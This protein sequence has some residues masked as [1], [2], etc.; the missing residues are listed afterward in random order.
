MNQKVSK[1][2]IPNTATAMNILSGFLSIIFVSQQDFHTGALLIFMA[3]FFD[4]IDGILARL[5]KTTSMF[6]VELDSIADV[7]SFG[8]APAFLI[9]YS[10]LI[11]YETVGIILSSLV[12]LFGA[13]R[14]ARFNVQIE[15]IQIKLDFNGLPIPVSALVIASLVL[16]YHNG[17]NIIKPFDSIVIPS[18][19]V[20]SL[21]MVSNIKYNTLP[22]VNKLD[23]VGKLL[24]TIISVGALVLLVLTNGEAIFYL[25]WFHILYGIFRYLY[26]KFFNNEN[27]IEIKTNK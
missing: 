6:G 1:S 16:F 7:I 22:K 19:I 17:I 27:Q 2:V 18:V 11:K 5:T 12:L 3:A 21:L 9:Y 20:L 4:S 8:V 14:L 24:F 26:F 13:F 10:H 25:L 23:S 15:D